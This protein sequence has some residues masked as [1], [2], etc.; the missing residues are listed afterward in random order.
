MSE[1]AK[2]DEAPATPAAER[3]PYQ[4]PTLTEYGPVAKLT[5]GKTGTVS[6]GKRR[7]RRR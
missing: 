6:D 4:P 1:I 7:R 3:K 5:M 2:K